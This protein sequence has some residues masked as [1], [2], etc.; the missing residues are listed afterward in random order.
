[1]PQP[2][3]YGPLIR[4]VAFVVFGLTAVKLLS[5]E[6]LHPYPGRPTNYI[7]YA[8]GSAVFAVCAVLAW[9]VA[10]EAFPP[11]GTLY[12]PS[13]WTITSID[14]FV[15]PITVG[16]ML[17]VIDLRV[18]D[19]PFLLGFASPLLLWRPMWSFTRGQPI[20][21][22]PA[23]PWL[24]W[25]QEFPIKPSFKWVDSWRGTKPRKHIGWQLVASFGDFKLELEFVALDTPQLSRDAVVALW[26]EKL[27]TRVVGDAATQAAVLN[28]K[29]VKPWHLVAG[30]VGMPGLLSLL[31][32]TFRSA[33][34]REGPEL[35]MTALVLL[36]TAGLSLWFISRFVS[37]TVLAVLSVLLAMICGVVCATSLVEGKRNADDL[38]LRYVCEGR[39]LQGNEP[40]QGVRW[41]THAGYGFE[42]VR[43]EHSPGLPKYVAC[44]R[45]SNSAQEKPY[46]VDCSRTSV[47]VTVRRVATA[48]VVFTRTLTGVEPEPF[49]QAD[50]RSIDGAPPPRAAIEAEILRSLEV[51]SGAQ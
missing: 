18:R 15:T 36:G 47:E 17:S 2:I 49:N 5:H 41:F 35:G 21:R 45:F 40:G 38:Q 14:L 37:M 12:L 11:K 3:L 4:S 43:E 27:D 32:E 34:L 48:E 33:N 6:A 9:R 1:M 44:Q 26:V 29:S 16:L 25:K 50:P 51:S 22:F 46:R 10:M 13:I 30:V 42:A 39:G 8:L 24:P 23:G 28:R 7:D 20:I 19:L 31:I